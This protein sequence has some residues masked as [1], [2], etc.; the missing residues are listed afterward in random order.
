MKHC[1][2]PE[3]RKPGQGEEKGRRGRRDE[4]VFEEHTQVTTLL[5]FLGSSCFP[6]KE[7]MS[8][9]APETLLLGLVPP[10]LSF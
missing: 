6:F 4:E 8:Y 2:R 1:K 10:S 3:W 5:L 7:E 9:L